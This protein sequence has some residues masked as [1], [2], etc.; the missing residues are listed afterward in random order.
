MLRTIHYTHTTNKHTHTHTHTQVRAKLYIYIYNIDVTSLLYCSITRKR[1]YAIPAN[2]SLAVFCGWLFDEFSL[3]VRFL[4]TVSHALRL[5]FTRLRTRNINLNS[6]N[7]SG[8]NWRFRKKTINNKLTCYL[9]NEPWS[10][11]W[12]RKAISPI[13]WFH[14]VKEINR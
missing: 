8:Y 11:Q 9:V 13:F 2:D 10:I 3:F 4:T 5:N 12:S 7:S 6:R 1:Y 14:S